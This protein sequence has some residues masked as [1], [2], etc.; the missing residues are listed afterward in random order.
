MNEWLSNCELKWNVEILFA[1]EAGSKAWDADSPGS[2]NDLRFIYRHRDIR[3]YLSL[4]N[5]VEVIDINEPIDGHGWDIFKALQLAS[6]SNPSLYEWAFSPI[7]YR[8][9]N[10]FA[11]RLR[12]VVVEHYSHYTVAMHYLSLIGRNL[13]ELKHRNSFGLRQQKQLIHIVRSILIIE[14]ILD[15]GNLING[16]FF[17]IEEKPKGSWETYYLLLVEAKK[18]ES[19]LA[20]D[21]LKKMIHR[22]ETEKEAIES[23]CQK[24]S[25]GQPFQGK[26]NEWL[27][28]LLQV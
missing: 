4:N 23:K 22:L 18:M 3:S 20:E 14:N 17:Q 7:V 9:E 25:K 1:C 10:D 27:W 11:K 24:L 6:K 8:N 2:D 19:V 16:P 21:L 5:P 26:L 13:K 12:E 28:E 15:K